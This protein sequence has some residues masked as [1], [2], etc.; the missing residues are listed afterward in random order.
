[1]TLSTPGATTAA[2][3]ASDKYNVTT[4]LKGTTMTA[5][6]SA[7]GIDQLRLLA[8]Q[9]LAKKNKLSV[10]EKKAAAIKAELQDTE[11]ALLT[12]LKAGKLQSVR[13]GNYNFTPGERS[14]LETHDWDAY[15]AWARKDR[16]GVYVERR[17]AKKAVQ[18]QL[19]AGVK[20]PGVRPGKLPVLH[21]SKA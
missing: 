21:I 8:K 12:A 18:E 16:L 20:V 11:D 14:I 5:T 17:P 4:N 10:A 6:N 15:W 7:P 3:G 1:M 19:E 13:V 2:P 9:V